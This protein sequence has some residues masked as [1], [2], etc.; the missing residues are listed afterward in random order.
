MTEELRNQ[1]IA[2]RK[3][4]KLYKEIAETFGLSRP[5]VTNICI[6]AGLKVRKYE[7][8][9]YTVQVPCKIGDDIWWIDDEAPFV[10]CDKGGVRG[11][12]IL[13]EGIRVINSDGEFEEIG[14]RY[15][16]LTRKDAERALDTE[17]KH[18]IEKIRKE[19]AE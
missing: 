2:A 3:E 4:G 19:K 12:A 8:R 13:P 16:Y 5:Y 17:Y 10:K 11:I 6:K 18:R 1:I 14:T 15:C 7:K 9:T